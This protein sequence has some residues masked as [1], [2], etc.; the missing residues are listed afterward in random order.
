MDKTPSDYT[1]LIKDEFTQEDVEFSINPNLNFSLALRLMRK[2]EKNQQEM[3]KVSDKIK[4]IREEHNVDNIE[5]TIDDLTDKLR[6]EENEEKQKELEKQIED[7]GK[8]YPQEL[9]TLQ[10]KAV[11][12]LATHERLLVKVSSLILHPVNEIPDDYG[13]KKEM[14]EELVASES[15]Y[16]DIVSFFLTSSNSITRSPSESQVTFRNPNKSQKG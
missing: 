11:D 12:I 3:M 10:R 15:T 7:I 9:L 14:I 2:R 8:K 13:S 5:T 1:L 4:K 6:E 16:S